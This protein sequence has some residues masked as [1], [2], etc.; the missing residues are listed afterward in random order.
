MPSSMKREVA[1]GM[2]AGLPRLGLVPHAVRTRRAVGSLVEGVSR[3]PSVSYIA[4]A[5]GGYDTISRNVLKSG[6][7]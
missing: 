1:V 5:S 3:E 7:P 6:R 2:C 4:K